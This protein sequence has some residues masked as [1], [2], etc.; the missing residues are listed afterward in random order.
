MLL[1]SDRSY[2]PLV[3]SCGFRYLLYVEVF[4]VQILYKIWM[5]GS[6]IECSWCCELQGGS[7]RKKKVLKGW[8]Q[9]ASTELGEAECLKS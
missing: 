1:S 7:G 2:F 5:L 8:G 4:S 9:S 6:F 3:A